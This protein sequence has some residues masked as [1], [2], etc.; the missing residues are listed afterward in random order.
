[1]PTEVEPVPF[2]NLAAQYQRLKPAI[3]DAVEEVFERQAFIQGPY[4]DRFARSFC[5]TIDA[6]YG[7]GCA[8]GT[9]AV[10]LALMGAGVGPGDEVIT[11]AHTFIAT[12]E[13]ISQL[14]ATPVFVDIDPVTY[15][16]DPVA[17]ER[18]VTER[19]KAI[20]PVHIYGGSC[21]MDRLNALAS[22]KGLKVVEDAAQAHLATYRGRF[23]GTLGATAAFSFYPGKNLGAF[24]DAGFVTAKEKSA[25]DLIRRSLDHGRSSK[26][27]HE[28]IGN[29]YRMDGVQAAILSVKLP[30]LA[31]WIAR[32][33]EIAATYDEALMKRGFTVA[34][35][36]EGCVSAYHLYVVEVANREE[37]M[38]RLRDERIGC[39]VHYPV[40]LHLQPAYASPTRPKGS[41][42]HTERAASRVMS[43]PICP[44]MRDGQVDRVIDV[45]SRVGRP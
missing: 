3:M 1:M 12:A 11:V 37:T 15:T 45:F 10:A 34:R 28:I 17:A 43:L 13:A 40:P 5:E 38:G 31:G 27:E 32:R 29:N 24:G 42:P 36:V 26:Y 30:H 2:L 23:A 22:Q 33:R 7:V 39:G 21:D 16:I 8:N 44:E 6:E 41:L 19:T 9:S 35:P 4:A 14:G 25:A 18:A 20:L